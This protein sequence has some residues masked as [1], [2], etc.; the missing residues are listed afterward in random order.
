MVAGSFCGWGS[1]SGRAFDFWGRGWG[2]VQNRES[3]DCRSLV[4]GISAHYDGQL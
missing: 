1:G 2:V 3:P 4:L